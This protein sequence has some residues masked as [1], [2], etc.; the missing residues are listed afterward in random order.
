MN[1][2]ELSGALRISPELSGAFKR[3][4]E[5]CGVP[6]SS[7]KHFEVFPNSTK[8]PRAVATLWSSPELP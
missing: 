6:Q 8:V 7:P 2:P 1:A 5:L 3:P 4:P